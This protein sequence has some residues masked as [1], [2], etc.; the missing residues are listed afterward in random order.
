MKTTLTFLV[1][2]ILAVFLIAPGAVAQMKGKPSNNNTLYSYTP[3]LVGTT[4]QMSGRSYVASQK[5]TTENINVAGAREVSISTTYNDSV[6]VIV[7]VQYR[8]DAN[9]AWAWIAGDTLNQT[10]GGVVTTATKHEFIL[11]GPGVNKFT[12]FTGD[13]RIIQS[14][15]ATLCGVTSPTYT[16]KVIWRP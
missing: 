10:G 7:Y 1:I 11:K 15:Q 6:Y 13:M 5:D 9:A 3:V 14:F 2:A 4:T 12:G 16:S 8:A